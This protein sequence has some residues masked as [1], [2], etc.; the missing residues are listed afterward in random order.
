VSIPRGITRAAL[1]R[2]G[3][4][5]GGVAV[6]GAAAAGG[7]PDVATSAPSAAQ[8]VRVLNFV[9][10]LERLEDAFYERAL[11]TRGLRADVQEFVRVV[12][13][14][15]RA[16]VALLERTLGDRADEP[17]RLD[18]ASATA[19]QASLLRSARTLEDAVVSAYNGQATNLTREALAPAARIASVESR[20]AAWIRALSGEAP[21]PDPTDDARTEEQ[22]RSA[23][24][25][26]GLLPRP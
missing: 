9:L 13:R 15:E 26:A 7:L 14:H 17:P 12:G 8:D 10:L 20:H 16:H 6:V 19:D 18:L 21:A 3:A 4:A 11:Q 2:G 25:D 24:A 5:A 23:L 1:L 22:V